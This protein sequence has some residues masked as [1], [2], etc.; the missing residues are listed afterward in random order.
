MTFVL[1]RALLL[2][3]CVLLPACATNMASVATFGD[4]TASV[5][6]QTTVVLTK[7]PESCMD[8]VGM[9]SELHEIGISA[10]SRRTAVPANAEAQRAAPSDIDRTKVTQLISALPAQQASLTAS[11][12]RLSQLTT[13]M[14]GVSGTLAAY[15]TAIKALAQDQ[16]VTYKPEF[17]SLPKVIGTI[18]KDATHTLLTTEQVTALDGLQKLI[19]TAAIQSYRQTKLVE[20]LGGNNETAVVQVVAALRAVAVAYRE[21]L[22]LVQ[23]SITANVSAIRG[24]QGGGFLFEPIAQQEFAIRM[25]AQDRVN[26]AR[27]EA[28]DQYVSVLD[29]V[30]PAFVKARESVTSAPTKDILLE[31]KDFAQ[32]AY[33]V[34]Q[35]MQK[36]F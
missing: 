8:L 29:K 25:N 14:Q 13:A 17:D 3:L 30:H 20:V 2:G 11:C 24:L 4:A 34:Q 12:S 35:K 16:F 22:E 15:A 21:Q 27:R 31:I 19:Y 33:E 36:A 9:S 10:L 6:Q 5:S 1:L 23:A 26:V 28:L 7:M 18:P 32:S